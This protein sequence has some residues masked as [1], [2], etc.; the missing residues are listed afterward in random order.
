MQYMLLMQCQRRPGE[1]ASVG[2]F[3]EVRGPAMPET[4][5]F[6]RAAASPRGT[7]RTGPDGVLERISG[8]QVVT[9]NRAV[10]AAM[11]PGPSAG[12]AG[13]PAAPLHSPCPAR[14]RIGGAPGRPSVRGCAPALRLRGR[15]YPSPAG[16][17]AHSAAIRFPIRRTPVP[18]GDTGRSG[19]G[20]RLS[21]RGRWG[22]RGWR[23]G[24]TRS[25]ERPNPVAPCP[26]LGSF[27]RV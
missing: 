17:S 3:V 6:A 27:L 12:V 15:A 14:G 11:V 23:V 25:A 1:R 16:V 24:G 21:P 19:T 2:E 8:N 4:A 20:H 22:G 18:A 26:Q 10:A 5:K 9:L 13:P 7:A